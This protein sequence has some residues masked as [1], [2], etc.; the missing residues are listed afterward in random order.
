MRVDGKSHKD[1]VEMLYDKDNP[2]TAME[3]AFATFFENHP[4][5]FKQHEELG[6][7]FRWLDFDL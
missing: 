2:C 7:I 1:I 6:G 4:E 5:L 3:Y